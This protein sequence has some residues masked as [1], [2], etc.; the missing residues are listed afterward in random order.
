MN[1]IQKFITLLAVFMLVF[2]GC[3]RPTLD[4]QNSS[5][6]NQYPKKRVVLYKIETIENRLN[7]ETE[8]EWDAL[9][10]MLCN[11]AQM[12]QKITFFNMNQTS[13]FQNN[14]TRGTQA[15]KTFSTTNRDEMKAWMKEREKE[16][17]TVEV[18]Y[19]NGTWHGMA[20]ASN[21]HT[22]T[23]VSI[24]GSW[25]FICSIV[26]HIDQNGDLTNADVYIPEENGGS[27]F[28]NFYDDG[29]ITL[30]FKAID[31][32]MVTDNSTWTLGDDGEL[33]SELLPNNGCWNVNWITNNTMIISRMNFGTDTDGEN[34]LY[35][36]QFER[37]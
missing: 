20:Y 25:H 21:P 37:E 29:T 27:M 5:E 4:N 11:Q 17:L 15:T 9:L 32:T 33:Y 7:L 30:T 22:T 3:E 10:D 12:G 23:S 6:E 16:G 24:V 35:Q 31:G 8:G 36:L 2:S 26:K 14:T 28:Y 18:T 13:I 34:T 1:I 19:S